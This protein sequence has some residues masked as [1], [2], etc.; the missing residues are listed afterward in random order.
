MTRDFLSVTPRDRAEHHRAAT[1]LELF[2]DL[3]SV[4]AIASAAHGLAHAI[5]AGHT[6]EGL[7]GYAFSFFAI[8]WAW[9]NYT[10]FASAYD[11][12]RAWFR[13][14]T[15]VIIFGALMMAA[16]I[17][18]L[19]ENKPIYLI[20][21]GFVVMRLGQVAL[22]LAAARGD[23]GHRT[24]ALRYAMG[25]TL[26]QVYWTA[27]FHLLSTGTMIF[28]AAFV[29]GMVLELSVP[30]YAE[31]AIHTPWHRHHIIERY[32]LLNIIVLG[33]GLLAA[34]AALRKSGEALSLAD[35]LLHVAI[36]AAVI[37]FAMWWAYFSRE[38][39]L[40][41]QEFP[42]AIIWGYGH[43]FVFASAAAV[44]AGFTV[45]TEVLTHHAE[46]GLHAGDLA[47]AIPLAIYLA[48]IWFVRDRYL[49]ALGMQ[50]YTLLLGALT[51][52]S[53]SLLLPAGLEI[54]AALAVAFVSVRSWSSGA[55]RA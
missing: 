1:P 47:V 43:V 11:N 40:E 18:A 32:G 3:A 53:A 28:N 39:H 37:T 9:M 54:I 20:W 23:P 19:F 17:S 26:A 16:G 35:P 50:R 4:V 46:V 55:T 14:V 41:T 45:L 49:A 10:W 22:W 29:L 27:L 33:E 7:V 36:S 30:V 2:Y 42:R 52:L 8:W 44:G 51:I 34:S 25:I 24:T 5:A 38:E 13:I 31:R 48:A 21:L 6:G 12:G 15:L